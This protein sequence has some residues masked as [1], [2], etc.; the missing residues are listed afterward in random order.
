MR[1]SLTLLAAVAV[2]ALPV[3]AAA[4]NPT[5]ELV[6]G[7]AILLSTDSQGS[8]GTASTSS[9]TNI[10]TP[11]AYLDYKRFGSEPSVAVD[12]YPGGGDD[13]YSC[14]PLGVGYPGFSYFFR[15][16]DL[17][18]TWS[19]PLHDPI[20][21]RAVTEGQG[22]GDCHVA[23][24]QM[25][26]RVFFVDLSGPDETISVSDDRGQSF[27]SA[28]L[29]SGLAPGTIDDRP[30]LA[31][32]ELYPGA[33]KVYDSFIDY[34][35]IANPTLAVAISNQDG[36]PGTYGEGPCN[37]ATVNVPSSGPDDPTACPDPVDK[38]LQVAGPTVVDVY[39]THDVYIPYIRGTSI[40]PGLTAG[41]PWE[42][43]VA[44]SE[45]GGNTWTRHEVALL[46][47]HN[48]S[49][50]FPE[51]TVDK[52]GNLYFTWSQSQG[53]VEDTSGGSGFFGEQ[54]VYYA[55]STDHGQ[56]WSP[57]INLT[58]ET[59]DSAVFPWM[60][61]G[62]PGQ[63]DLVYY[64]A[65]TGLNS[66]VAFVD[67]N[68]NPCPD[69]NSECGGRENPSVWNTFFAQSQ[70]AL[71]TGPNFKSV[72][73]TDHPN[74]LGQVC[75]LGL[76]CSGNRNL[77]DFISVD[78]DHLGA[79][80]VVWS[81]DNNSRNDTRIKFSRQVAGNSVF[82]STTINLQS[83]WPIYDHA[84]NDPVGDVTDAAGVP[85]GS[86][87]GMD[88]LKAATSRSGD[89]LMLSLTLNAPPTMTAA[90]G[91]GAAASGGLWGAEFWASDKPNDNYYVGYRANIDGTG[92]EAGRMAAISPTETSNEFQKV[93]AG[94]G[95]TCV[96]LTTPPPSAPTACTLTMT[97]SLSG[98]GIKP[99]AGLYSVTGLSVY[100]FGSSSNIPGTRASFGI[101]NQADATAA[102]DDNGTGTT[103]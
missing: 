101:S 87:A 10:F 97:V 60:V 31:V 25:T 62:D 89:L 83:S 103:R 74:H 85:E 22:G 81:D 94:T 35:N 95:G 12:R 91:C 96:P 58:K 20:Y 72:Q 54:D 64:K 42:L 3:A 82:K 99:G 51:M 73:I 29:G 6:P 76:A 11:S 45:N 28:P 43:W 80:N 40:I 90:V 100:L 2:L 88:V 49:N 61:A 18:A 86:C 84:A 66:N 79:A 57:P 16:L 13:A 55:F 50:I 34:T 92:V 78:V 33:Q 70:N 53:P 41:P 4:D 46:G 26:H 47:D 75:T 7:T 59:G 24:G 14:G 19:L 48:P 38:Q 30:W 56:T 93:E 15:S 69:P 8:G 44:R 21:G 1:L 102:L 63:V 32:D 39:N 65:S 98:L 36:T 68:G 77:A 67:A 52:A 71:N 9:M 5:T 37:A 27:V 17:G 23:V